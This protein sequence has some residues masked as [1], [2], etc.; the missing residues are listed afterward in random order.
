MPS[1]SW[2]RWRYHYPQ[3]AFPYQGLI[4]GNTRRSKEDREYE[5]IDTGI[6]DED[7]YWIT[8]VHY[9]KADADDILMRITVKNAGPEADEIHVLPTLW[10]RNTWAYDPDAATPVLAAADDGAPRI[11]AS[12]PVLGDYELLAG[13]G[14][15][16]AAPT[17]LFCENETNSARIFGVE[18]TTPYPKDG[19]NDHVIGGSDTVNPARTG[20]KAAA[21]YRLTVQPGQDVELRL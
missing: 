3:G 19:I 18:P 8:E 5:L 9:A 4:A 21:W 6:F 11:T 7:R 12:H 17:L 16:G 13:T 14:P 1:S 20:T 15:D 10:F 2:L